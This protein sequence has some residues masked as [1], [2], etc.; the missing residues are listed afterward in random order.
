MVTISALVLLFAV[1]EAQTIPLNEIWAWRM[2]GTLDVGKL[3]AVK[4]PTEITQHPII[5]EI[6]RILAHRPEEGQKAG[7]AFVVRGV[8]KEALKNAYA[9][10]A[11]KKKAADVM[12]I[13]TDLS[14]VF[15]SYMCGRYVRIVSVEQ[16]ENVIKVQYRFVMHSTAEMTSHFALIPLKHPPKGLIEVRIQEVSPID[17][18]GEATPSIP[19]PLRIIPDSFLFEVKP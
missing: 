17:E 7:A 14:V 12:P 8:G 2:P 9:V 6:T 16:S 18:R 10:L 19:E 15:Y 3:D 11:K 4:T 13:D 5:N 1:D